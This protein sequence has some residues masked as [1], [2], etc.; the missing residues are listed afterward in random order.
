MTAGCCDMHSY[1]SYAYKLDLSVESLLTY[2]WNHI[3]GI[4]LDVQNL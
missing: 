4:Y 3:K 1:Q 2:Q